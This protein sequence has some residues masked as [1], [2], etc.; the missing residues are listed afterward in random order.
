MVRDAGAPEDAAEAEEVKRMEFSP[1]QRLRI[2][3]PESAE[4]QS[5]TGEVDRQSD[6]RQRARGT[7]GIIQR[8][9]KFAPLKRRP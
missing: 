5:R 6:Q 9:F 3:S 2:D 4:R 8:L 1:L 7:N